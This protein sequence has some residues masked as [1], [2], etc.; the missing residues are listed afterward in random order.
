MKSPS[1]IICGILV[2]LLLCASGCT[3]GLVHT[4]ELDSAVLYPQSATNTYQE[5]AKRTDPRYDGFLGY[6]KRHPEVSAILVVGSKGHHIEA[7]S[8]E[9]VFPEWS[10]VSIFELAD[11]GRLELSDGNE[12]MCYDLPGTASSRGGKYT[13]G[14]IRL[15]KDYTAVVLNL[16]MSS[17][18]WF[19][20][21]VNHSGRYKITS[22]KGSANQA[23]EAM[24]T[25]GMSAAGQ[26][27][28]QP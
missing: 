5:P 22:V 10:D 24:A 27:P 14:T 26:P 6:L 8:P 28:R 23:R 15:A 7:I 21:W 13:K 4:R 3:F 12:W 25:A 9:G 2:P 19:G 18:Y 1:H 17:K 11:S 16:K 20:D